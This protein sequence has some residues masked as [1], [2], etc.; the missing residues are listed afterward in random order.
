MV[1]D[2]DDL[3]SI[4][5][6]RGLAEFPLENANGARAAN[7]VRHQNVDIHPNVIAGLHMRFA[8]GAGK[9]F[10]GQSHRNL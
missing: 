1:R 9:D 7:V 8:A 6:L 5:N 10:L 2:D 4:P 3:L